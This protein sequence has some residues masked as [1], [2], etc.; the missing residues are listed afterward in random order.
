M[1]LN[2]GKSKMVSA[3]DWMPGKRGIVAAAVSAS[4]SFDERVQVAGRPC[5]SHVLLWTFQDPIHPWVII[6]SYHNFCFL[7]SVLRGK[8]VCTGTF[9]S[10]HKCN[11][12]TLAC[13]ALKFL[14]SVGLF[15]IA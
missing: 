8:F 10:F 12:N 6:L 14:F 5:S 9:I 3:I 1:D 15:K 4:S 7:L 11:I 2:Y 13:G